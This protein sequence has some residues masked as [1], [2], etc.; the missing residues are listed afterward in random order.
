MNEG[1]YIV[2]GYL[3]DFGVRNFVNLGSYEGVYLF[4]K[5][6]I[7]IQK[8]FLECEKSVWLTEFL[9]LAGFGKIHK[10]LASPT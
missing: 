9:N 1:F 4:G 10:I 6:G 2:R 8:I 7:I 5:F 3:S